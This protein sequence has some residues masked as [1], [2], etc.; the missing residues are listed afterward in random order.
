MGLSF[1]L[2][3]TWNPRFLA[4]IRA[5][6][7]ESDGPP[8]GKKLAWEI[9][10]DGA[11]RGWI[12]LGEP[13]FKLAPRRR[14]GLLDAR[15]LPFTVG[16]FIFR[17]DGTEE[18]GER[19]SA[20]L[21]AWHEPASIDWAYWCGWRPVHWETLVDPEKV[22]STGSTVPGAC[23]RRAGYRSLGMTTGRGASRPPGSTHG[24][25]VWGNKS[26]KLVLY[27]GPLARLPSPKG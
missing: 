4:A 7:T 13:S 26:P 14:L 23:Y 3:S 9:H 24:A 22:K 10:E 15:P 1:R 20:I 27:R 17:L 2:L 25:R 12:G 19:A 18:D 8:P 6:Y 21:K 16:N 11:H 5:H